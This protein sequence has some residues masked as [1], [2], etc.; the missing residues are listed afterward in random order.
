MPDMK[1]LARPFKVYLG[2]VKKH[3]ESIFLNGFSWDCD[4]YWG[5]GYLGNSRCHFHFDGAFLDTPDRRGH[6]LGNFVTPWDKDPGEGAVVLRNGC[7]VWENISTFLDNTPEHISA[8]WW[9]IKELYKQFYALKSA[10]ETFRYGGHCTSEGRAEAEI[11]LDMAE[12]IN[13]HIGRV[14]IPEV[15]KVLQVE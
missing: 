15:C 14:I 12:K 3:P 6:P 4:W 10:A 11:N 13:L 8:N 2:S 9:R 1:A 5:G 7:S